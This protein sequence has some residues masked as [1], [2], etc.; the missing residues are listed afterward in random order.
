MSKINFNNPEPTTIPAPT[1]PETAPTTPSP[2]TKPGNDPWSVPSPSVN[3]T[4]KA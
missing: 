4:P 2:N 1:K 3:P